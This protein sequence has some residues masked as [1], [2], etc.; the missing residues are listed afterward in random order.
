MAT[1]PTW[2]MPDVLF[3][4]VEILESASVQCFDHTVQPE[5]N[6]T[7]HSHVDNVQGRGDS[8]NALQGS[9]LQSAYPVTSSLR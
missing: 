9:K 3:Y 8:F 6:C 5:Y 4:D 7:C 1:S 2:D